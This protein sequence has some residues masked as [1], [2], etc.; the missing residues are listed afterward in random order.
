MSK[1]IVIALLATTCLQG[2]AHAN[3]PTLYWSVHNHNTPIN[4]IDFPMTIVEAKPEEHFYYAYQFAFTGGGDI[5]YTGIQ[6]QPDISGKTRLRIVFSSFRPESAPHHH[7]CSSGADNGPGTSCATVIDGEL[8]TQYK[9]HVEKKGNLVTGSIIN[10]TTGKT[11]IVGKWN[12][13]EDAGTFAPTQIAWA[14]NFQ[15]KA[16]G[17]VLHCNASGWPFYQV[18]YGAPVANGGTVTGQITGIDTYDW[19]DIRQCP[20][21]IFDVQKNG[22]QAITLGAGFKKKSHKLLR[23]PR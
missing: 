4:S 22:D 1:R 7:N 21:A 13:S 16:D 6:P 18:T 2:M 3:S 19:D 15:L 5:G 11:H 8:G 23:E 12:V 17:A 10:G 14:E 9:L 20:D